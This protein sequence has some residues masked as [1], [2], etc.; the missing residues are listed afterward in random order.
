MVERGEAAIN[1]AL[2]SY[3]V[4]A[5]YSSTDPRRGE[6][7]RTG[8]RRPIQQRVYRLT[9]TKEAGSRRRAGALSPLE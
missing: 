7:A 4:R 2:N 3:G 8:Y 5:G 6:L 1:A 9:P